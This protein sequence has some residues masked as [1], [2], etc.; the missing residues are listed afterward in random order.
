MAFILANALIITFLEDQRAENANSRETTSAW[1]ITE[2]KRFNTELQDA[3]AATTPPAIQGKIAPDAAA[4]SAKARQAF[5]MELHRKATDLEME[6]RSLIS[7][8]RLVSLAEVP[9][10][11]IFPKRGPILAAGFMLAALL[12]TLGAL[13]QDV[14]DRSVRRT[15]DLR[16]FTNIPVLGSLPAITGQEEATGRSKLADRLGEVLK[17]L[18]RRKSHPVTREASKTKASPKESGQPAWENPTILDVCYTLNARL[19]LANYDKPRRV[20]LISSGAPDEGKTLTTLAL[21][22]AAAKS[23]RK[24]LVVDGD[25]KSPNLTIQ[26]GLEAT[27]GVVDVLRDEVTPLRAIVDTSQ[28]NLKV[29]PAGTTSTD[30]MVLLIDRKSAKLIEATKHYDLVFIDGASATSPLISLFAG[31]AD[32]L[33]LCARWGRTQLLDVNASLDGLRDV[34]VPVAGVIVT[35]VDPYE[36]QFFEP[37]SRAQFGQMELAGV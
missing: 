18:P 15:A 9:K 4:T 8:A 37:A 32:A 10:L 31:S 6:R 2:A 26:M 35:M 3:S 16:A 27:A 5:L 1:L 29:M 30:P 19:A 14:T 25:L 36:Q 7:S 23:G 11:P 33:L 20:F 21:A 17:L 12:A 28:P 22:S 13:R 24:V 34:G